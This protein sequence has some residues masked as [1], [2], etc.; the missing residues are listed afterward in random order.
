MEAQVSR[1]LLEVDTVTLQ[2]QTDD[3]LITATWRASFDVFP[4]DRFVLLGPSGCG[5]SSLL[6]A[7]CRKAG[8][9]TC[10]KFGQQPSSSR[11]PVR[12]R[13]LAS[14]SAFPTSFQ[15]ACRP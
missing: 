8:H 3:H 4:S 9:H 14:S 10:S 2:Y 7:R 12:C 6:K 11:D 5:K 13:Q 15:I 1:P